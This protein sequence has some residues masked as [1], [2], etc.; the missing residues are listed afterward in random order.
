MHVL[1]D[2]GWAV[3]ADSR[4]NMLDRIPLETAY[5]VRLRQPPVQTARCYESLPIKHDGSTPSG[6]DASST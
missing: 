3:A 4:S 5:I 1:I 2:G 6:I